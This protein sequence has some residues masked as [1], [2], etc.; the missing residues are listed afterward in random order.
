MR[1]SGDVKTK[2]KPKNI[3]GPYRPR[4]SD[5]AKG[6]DA[7]AAGLALPTKLTRQDPAVCRA[8]VS[9]QGFADRALDE[10]ISRARAS[11]SK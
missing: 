9:G 10:V 6:M 1:Y 11:A 4:N 7:E 5:C 3:V 2:H 8:Q